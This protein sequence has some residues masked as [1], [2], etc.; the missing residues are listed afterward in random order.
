MRTFACVRETRN[1]VRPASGSPE[2]C[3][4]LPLWKSDLCDVTKGT[5]VPISRPDACPWPRP[6][7]LMWTHIWSPGAARRCAAR[8]LQSRRVEGANVGRTSFL[9]VSA[10]K[11]RLLRTAAPTAGSLWR[12]PPPSLLQPGEG[13]AELSVCG[14]KAKAERLCRQ[15]QGH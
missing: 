4:L 7:V 15:G 10:N 5:A 11:W 9:H 3:V 6:D 14:A 12:P 8:D 13:P 1:R 2:K